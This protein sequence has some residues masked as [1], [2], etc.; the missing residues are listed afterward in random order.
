[1]NPML[2]FAALAVMAQLAV[3]APVAHAAP[4][5]PA[6]P[7]ALDATLELL[8]EIVEAETL[9]KAQAAVERELAQIASGLPARPAP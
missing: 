1:M 4:A 9:A 3:A 2:S 8:G 6:E 5:E 7:A